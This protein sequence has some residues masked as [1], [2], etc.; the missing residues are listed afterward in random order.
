MS[1]KIFS[2]FPKTNTNTSSSTFYAE[3]LPQ[4][5]QPKKI[6]TGK[7]DNQDFKQLQQENIKLKAENEKLN[8]EIVCLR[9]Q[10]AKKE[11][12][13][14]NLLK[15][16]KETCRMYVNSEMKFKIQTKKVNVQNEEVLYE[17]FKIVF[18]ENILKQLRKIQGEKNRDSSFIL[19]CIRA[20]FKDIDLKSINAK[21]IRRG[22]SALPSEKREI[23]ERIFSERLA[24]IKLTDGEQI[25]RYMALNRHINVAIANINRANV[26]FIS[27]HSILLFTC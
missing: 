22:K 20:L 17:T 13:L 2:F 27:L 5:S 26:S 1:K 21:G 18:G 12:D 11:K 15:I 25:E 9:K 7:K 6:A 19:I 10:N 4:K 14:K 24:S 16:H 23:I 3:N 8:A